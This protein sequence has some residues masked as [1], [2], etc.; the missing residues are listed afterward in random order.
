MARKPLRE[1]R[2]SGC[3]VLTRG[4]YCDDHMV[5][6]QERHKIYDTHKRDKV[7][8]KFYQSIAWQ[9]ARQS[10]MM[11]CYGLC[12]DCLANGVIMKADIVHHIKPLRDYPELATVQ[13]N[14]KP[15]C[16]KCHGKY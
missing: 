16:N 11:R 14:L 1:C 7:T 10:A 5:L 8:S 2:K 3:H 6:H 4:Y 13:D 15:L 9:K 12:Q